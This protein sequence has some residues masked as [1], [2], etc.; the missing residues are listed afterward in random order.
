MSPL[1]LGF[2]PDEHTS[3]DE[4]WNKL[5]P[6]GIYYVIEPP[7]DARGHNWL[8][9]YR[10]GWLGQ[11]PRADRIPCYVVPPIYGGVYMSTLFTG[12]Q[13][14]IKTRERFEKAGKHLF[15]PRELKTFFERIDKVLQERHV[16][17]LAASMGHSDA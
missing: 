1:L 12:T 5:Y 4:K 13:Y 11:R 17:A 8:F 2:T 7:Q 6:E 10:V 9:K 3:L 16:Q 15:T 14:R